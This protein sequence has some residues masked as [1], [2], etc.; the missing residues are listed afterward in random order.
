MGNVYAYMRISTAEERGKQG[1]SRQ[2]K[3]LEAYAKRNRIDYVLDLK[4]DVSGKSF[5]NRKEWQRLEKIAQS[6][7]TIVFKDLCRFTR[8]AEQGYDKYMALMQK[9][10][11]LVFI[12]NPTISTNYIKNLLNI[13]E[14]QELVTKTVMESMVKILLIS[15]LDRSEKERLIISQR[16]KDGLAARKKQAEEEGKEWHIGR[17]KGRLDKMSDSLKKD[18][19]KYQS[20]RTIKQVDLMRKYNIS[21]NTLKKY[22]AIVSSEEMKEV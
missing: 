12:D 17:P 16:T 14:Q 11:D 4:E 2:E 20:D 3:A 5:T 19:I 18:I 10:I 9:G 22:V 1:Y 7:D 13:A 6:G 15:E 21:R 8:Q